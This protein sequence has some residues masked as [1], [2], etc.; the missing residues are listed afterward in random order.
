[1]TYLRNVRPELVELVAHHTP[2]AKT[3]KNPQ[4]MSF[5]GVPFFFVI[6]GIQLFQ[7]YL[8]VADVVGIAENGIKI[9]GVQRGYVQQQR[10]RSSTFFR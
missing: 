6:N 2:D 3:Q 5:F 8:L 4:F 10:P 1:M 9:G 7:I